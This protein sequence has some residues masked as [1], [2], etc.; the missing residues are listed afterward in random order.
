MDLFFQN[1]QQ[2]FDVAAA[3][4]SAQSA[5][6]FAVLVGANGALHFVMEAPFSLEAAQAEGARTAYR[7][8]RSERDGIRVEGLEG[9]R[10]CLLEQPATRRA[11]HLLRDFPAYRMTSPA[12]ISAGPATVVSAIASRMY[13]A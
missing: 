13:L 1:A 10:R 9:D 5:T 12:L 11:L 4:D 3:S 7:V 2:L 8:I 6:D